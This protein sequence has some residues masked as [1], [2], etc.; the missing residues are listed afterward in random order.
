M[1]EDFHFVSTDRML[2]VANAPSPAATSAM[3]IAAHLADHVLGNV[4]AH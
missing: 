4:A 2:H 3:P 1:I